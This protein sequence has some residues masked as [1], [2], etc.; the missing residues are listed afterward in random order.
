MKRKSLNTIVTNLTVVLMTG[1]VGFTTLLTFVTV[2]ARLVPMAAPAAIIAPAGMPRGTIVVLLVMGLIGAW[3]YFGK[4]SKKARSEL[5]VK[6][7]NL[8]GEELPDV[9]LAEEAGEVECGLDQDHVGDHQ[10]HAH[11]DN[12]STG[13]SAAR[14]ACRRMTTASRSP[15]QRP[16]TSAVEY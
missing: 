16:C 5:W 4:A 6:L 7:D 15:R 14:S 9:G 13:G 8:A 1:L 11:G 3:W 2:M 12:P 10:R